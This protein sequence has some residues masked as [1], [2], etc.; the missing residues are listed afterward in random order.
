MLKTSMKSSNLAC[1]CRKLRS[2]RLGGFFLQGEMHAFVAAVLLRMAGLDPFDA[3]AQAQPPDGEFAQMKQGVRGSEG[4]AVIAADVGG[5][6]ALLKKPL[7]HSKSVVF[8]GGRKRL[9]GQQITAG[10]I[11]DG[12]RVAVVM[13]AQQELALVIGAPQLIGTLA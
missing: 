9:A 4:H 6:A 7:K 1:C 3:N 12:Q 8:S 2:G 10:M 13:I 11:G 5:Q